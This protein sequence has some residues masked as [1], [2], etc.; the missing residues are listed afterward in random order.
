MEMRLLTLKLLISFP[1]SSAVK[2][3]Y[4]SIDAATDG[5]DL[6]PLVILHGLFGS[7][8]NWRTLAKLFHRETGRRVTSF[9]LSF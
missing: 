7:K 6:P 1:L 2:L 4:N 3:A 5:E 9:F 8:Q